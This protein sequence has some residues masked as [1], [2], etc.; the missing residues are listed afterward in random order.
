MM[1]KLKSNLT[2]VICAVLGLLNFILLAF[3]YVKA[4]SE[5]N[6]GYGNY[7]ESM[8]GYRI[9]KIWGNDSYYFK[10]AK[11]GGVMSSTFQLFILLLGI[12]LLA[13]GV[14]GL[15]KAFGI[16]EKFPDKVG[17]L[18]SKKIGEFGLFGLAGLNVLLL[19]FLIVFTASNSEKISEHGITVEGGY[20]LSAGI[21]IAIIFTVGAAVAL[22]LLEKKFP[23]SDN[24]ES[25]TYV[26]KKC[27]K[28]AKA[29][30]KFCSSCGGEIE[31]KVVV[32]EEY[33]CV[34]CGKKATAKDKFCNAC[35]GEIKV[36]EAP[37]QEEAEATVDDV[38]PQE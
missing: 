22:K 3:N 30:D 26:C 38:A 7:S 32:K 2:Y 14:L 16:F 24:G 19:V 18:E 17:K 33:A 35:G 31:K 11:F 6:L 4:Y 21:F 10:D 8:S 13:W 25:V 15:L 27:G 9:L 20:K 34:K 5:S 12:A 28:K 1:N 36:K 29:K 37:P 23:A